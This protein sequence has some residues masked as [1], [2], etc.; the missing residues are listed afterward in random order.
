VLPLASYAAVNTARFGEPFSVPFEDQVFSDLDPRR[1]QVLEATGSTLFGPEF[2]PDALTTY[3]R[4]DGIRM[5]AL[6]PWVTF[7]EPG[8]IDDPTFDKVDRSASLPVVAP[9]F[10]GLSLAGVVTL[11]RDR[12]RDAWP[13]LAIGGVVGLTSTVTIAFIAHRYLADFTPSLVVLTAVGA[14]PVATWLAA[15]RRW[16]RRLGFAAAGAAVL[17]GFAVN[18]ALAVQAQRLF[19]LTEP[20][21]RRDFVAFQYEL[22]D[23]LGGEV[24]PAVH[25]TDDLTAFVGRR[26]DIAI[27]GGCDGLYWHD[28][29][30]WLPLELGARHEVELEGDVT[31][32]TTLASGSGWSIEAERTDDEVRLVFVQDGQPLRAGE[33]VDLEDLDGAPLTVAVDEVNGEVSVTARG[34]RV[35]HAW[36][37]D[38]PGPI[39][40]G[41]GWRARP[42]APTLCEALRRRL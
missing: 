1:Q 18:L 30:S 15:R 25:Q 5:Q 13:A 6:F 19:F 42:S 35:L 4:P 3:L 14:W 16:P 2:A 28:G 34:V 29:A 41:A 17:M 33:A 32:A 7:R 27:V 38:A 39:E 9:L 37:V 8:A 40:A 36:A 24:P 31:V 11:A 22:H 21:A 23:R 20:T 12:R 10:V 26:G